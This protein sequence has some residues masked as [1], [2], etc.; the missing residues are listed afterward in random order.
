MMTASNGRYVEAESVR[1]Q[2]GSTPGNAS[3]VLP[4]LLIVDDDPDITSLLMYTLVRARFAPVAA[5]DGNSAWKHMAD[6]TPD[7]VLLDWMLPEMSGIELLRRMRQDDRLSQ[8]PVIMLTARAEE[9]DRVHGLECGADDYI[10]KPFSPR[11]LCA[12]INSRLRIINRKQ[13]GTLTV[14]GLSLDQQSYRTCVNGS[15]VM[16][17]PTEF[18]LLRY[19]MNNTERVFSRGQILDNV[20]GPNVYID[21]RAVDV[22]IRRLRKAL[23]PFN[24]AG[25][26]QTVRGAGYRFSAH[27]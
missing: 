10:V 15:A 3:R 4:R 12:R 24:R 20:W 21:E 2:Q 25:L 11:E 22:H 8:V 17:G 7:L 19:F 6:A 18:R 5:A 26:I 13:S 1:Q 27:G 23:E 14:A 16:L 9:V